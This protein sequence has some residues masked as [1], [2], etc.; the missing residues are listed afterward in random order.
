MNE[1]LSLKILKLQHVIIT[2]YCKVRFRFT[3]FDIIVVGADI[4]TCCSPVIPIL[5]SHLSIACEER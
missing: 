3:Q 1:F 5:Q 2:R 4:F